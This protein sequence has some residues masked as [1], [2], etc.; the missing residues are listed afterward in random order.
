[1]WEYVEDEGDRLYECREI[2]FVVVMRV[3]LIFGCLDYFGGFVK[4]KVIGWVN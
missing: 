2:I 4:V 3:I 1:M